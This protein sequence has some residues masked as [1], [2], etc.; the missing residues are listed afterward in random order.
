ML[1]DKIRHDPKDPKLWELWYIPDIKGNAGFCPSTVV[2]DSRT[3]LCGVAGLLVVVVVAK[4][5]PNPNQT[6]AVFRTHSTKH[7]QTRSP[8]SRSPKP[9]TLYPKP[10]AFTLNPLPARFYKLQ[11]PMPL[12]WQRPRSRVLKAPGDVL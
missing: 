6:V 8:K 11:T 2:Q 4:R 7:G 9:Q 5:P 10:Q 3:W 12:L 1:M